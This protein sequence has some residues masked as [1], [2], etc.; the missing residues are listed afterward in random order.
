MEILPV[1]IR[2]ALQPQ[3]HQERPAQVVPGKLSMNGS[4]PVLQVHVERLIGRTGIARS[5]QQVRISAEELGNLLQSFAGSDSIHPSEAISRM[6]GISSQPSLPVPD[7]QWLGNEPGSTRCAPELGT[8]IAWA[9][10]A[11]LTAPEGSPYE[12]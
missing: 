6:Q 3:L 4:Y 7:V 8:K 1:S 10:Y 5:A 11:A 2:P 12:R 9:L